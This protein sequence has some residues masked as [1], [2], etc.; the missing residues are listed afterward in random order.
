MNVDFEVIYEEYYSK[1][2]NYVYYRVLNKQNA[3]D[4]VSDVFFKAMDGIHSF[5]GKRASVS[6]WLFRIATNTVNDLYRRGKNILHIPPEDLEL[7]IPD[8]ICLDLIHSEDLRRLHKCLEALDER[9][10]TVIAM[11]YWGEL[12]YAGVA[13]LTG[14]TEK[15]VSV[16]LSR[17]INKLRELFEKTF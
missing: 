6:T 2:Y 14:L 12:S 1:I 7:P 11:R 10:R 9:T 15:N 13:K 8:T 5:D 16:V 17:G 3:E 4:V